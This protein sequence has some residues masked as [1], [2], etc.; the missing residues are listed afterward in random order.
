[1][2]QKTRL[3]S[4]EIVILSALLI[5]MFFSAFY[6]LALQQA[7]A[8]DCNMQANSAITCDT[9]QYVTP[10][11]IWCVGIALFI[12]IEVL[13]RR[14]KLHKLKYIVAMLVGLLVVALLNTTAMASQGYGIDLLMGWNNPTV[15]EVAS[16]V[17]GASNNA[18]AKP[19]RPGYMQ[20][21]CGVGL[22][23]EHIGAAEIKPQGLPFVTEKQGACKNQQNAIAY[24]LNYVA[25]ATV[26]LFLVRWWTRPR[27]GV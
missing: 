4:V 14:A 27:V 10:F 9:N 26:A 5:C 22:C 13:L 24:G 19:T 12:V 21:G 2:K 17:C 23:S 15:A 6:F 1:M 18:A 11:V 8:A 7:G 3:K 25:G 16:S 20:L